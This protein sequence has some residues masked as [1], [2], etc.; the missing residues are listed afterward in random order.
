MIKGRLVKMWALSG[1]KQE[2]W[3]PRIWRRLRYSKTF[4]HQSSPASAPV[5]LS[6]SQTAKAGTGRTAHFR[7]RSG[8]RPSKEPEGA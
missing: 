3:L 7:R 8:S 1:M 5:T 6:K 2:T 4:L